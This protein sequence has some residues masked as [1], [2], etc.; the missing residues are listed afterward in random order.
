MP[1]TNQ[2]IIPKEIKKPVEEIR[3]WDYQ[4]VKFSPLSS[5]A[6]KKV[7]NRSSGNYAS[8]KKG[9]GPCI[10][11][12]QLNYDNCRCSSD[13]LDRQLKII[14]NKR[15]LETFE[16]ERKENEKER[17][18]RELREAEERQR[19]E[20][21]KEW[22]EELRRVEQRNNE[23]ETSGIFKKSWRGIVGGWGD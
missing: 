10:I 3:F 11:N 21:S 7:V 8:E 1:K 20:R 9:Y 4:E 23:N 18:E 2:Y 22:G 12:S 16:R 13:E 17:L 5:E 14:R 15:E 19:I 6:R